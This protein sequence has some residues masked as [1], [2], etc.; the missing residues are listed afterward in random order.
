MQ[1]H[2]RQ[3]IDFTLFSNLFIA[4]CA[5]AQTGF[6]Y[7]LLNLKPQLTVIALVFFA[8]LTLYN[9][10]IL[11]SKPPKPENSPFRRVRWIFAHQRLI[12]SITLIALVSV[13]ILA[14]FLSFATLIL[15]LFL[16]MLAI[17]YNLPL[18]RIK[19]QKIGLRNIPGMKLLMIAGVW[20][21]SVV[22][23]PL[24]ELENTLHITIPTSQIVLLLIH[25]FIFVAAISI[26]FDIRDGNQDR[27]NALKTIPVMFGEKAASRLCQRLLAS[28]LALAAWISGPTESNF[29]AFFAS[30]LISFWLIFKAK[31]QKNEYYYFFFLDGILILP[32]LIAAVLNLI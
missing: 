32:W 10:S 3:I 28:S 12:V 30:I 22:L 5:A 27:M 2:L 19:H 21:L 14:L 16:G 17:A 23:I 13:F 24:I 20:A 15:L 7:Q 31:W 29:W 4:L 6:T 9:F 8:T 26:P 18:I 11:V 1:K 25:R